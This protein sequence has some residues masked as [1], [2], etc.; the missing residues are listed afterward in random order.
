MPRSRIAILT[1]FREF[2]PGYSLTG[3]VSDQCHMLAE[4]DHPVTLFVSERFSE[5]THPFPGIEGVT[6]K[7]VIPDGDLVDYRTRADISTDH[8]ALRDRIVD[9]LREELIGIDFAIT[10][11]W[12]FTGWNLP[13]ALA[14]MKTSPLTEKWLRWGHWIHSIPSP[15]LD[16]WNIREYGKGQRIIF[17]NMSERTRVAEQY[18][19]H[20]NHVRV[21]PH[22]KDMRTFMDFDPETISFIKEY[23]AVMQADI[24]QIY[25]ASTDRLQAKKL[26]EVIIIF[27]I[28]KKMGFKVCLV[29][30]NQW[31]TGRQPKQNIE[32]YKKIA[33]RNDLKC[34]E[35]FVFTSE[36]KEKYVN[37]L[38]RRILRELL[39]CANLFI[40]PT[41]E[42]SF[43]LVAPE[44]AL[45]GGSLLV[46]NKSLRMMMEVNGMTGLYVDFGSYEY[47][48]APPNERDYLTGVAY[49]IV[50]RMR[51][52]ESI[53]S[54]TFHRQRYNW[55]NLYE[56]FYGPMLSECV[57]W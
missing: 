22:I 13:Y 44:V 48:F 43:G 55:N 37:G 47:A 12:I 34:G 3:I 35:E 39:H 8:E 21:I 17:P 53:N 7:K 38:P 5:K 27:A 19:G 26:R 52:N 57:T 45:A 23:P 33:R 28:L 50:G 18:R 14:I 31:A 29:C 25:P 2:N 11:D 51:E 15:M 24:V 54:K 10:H 40:F 42:E 36:W 20:L 9:V 41:Q 6:I 32:D 16:W 49:L 56:R 30:A 1:N 4:Y 46:L